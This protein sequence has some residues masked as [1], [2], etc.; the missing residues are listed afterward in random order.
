MRLITF[1]LSSCGI[2]LTCIPARAS[3]QSIQPGMWVA[4]CPKNEGDTVC[5]R[6]AQPIE[7]ASR[8]A[9]SQ[10]VAYGSLWRPSRARKP[11]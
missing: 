7:Q 4:H 5:A 11:R 1:S 10:R 3:A 6:D 9:P 8:P 2:A